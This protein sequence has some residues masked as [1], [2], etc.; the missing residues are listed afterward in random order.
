MFLLPVRKQY[1]F[2]PEVNLRKEICK[3]CRQGM[4][5]SDTQP[6][7]SNYLELLHCYTLPSALFDEEMPSYRAYV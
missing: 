7:S 3:C 2:L 4:V 6:L 5:K 1:V